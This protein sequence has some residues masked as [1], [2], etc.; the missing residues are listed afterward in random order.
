MFEF[1]AAPDI[2]RSS[3]LSLWS[4][5]G[6]FL[7]R[8]L[9][10]LIVFFIGGI[11]SV[12]LGKLAYY[13]VRALRID[14]ALRQVGFKEAWEK[15]GFKL[16]S[17]V[18]F[19]EIVRWFF[20]IVFLM[21]TMDILGLSEVS[22]FLQTVVLYIPNVFVAAIILLIGILLAKF[23]EETVR[24]SVRAAGLASGNF[25]GTLARWA[26]FVFS[27]LLALSQLN[28]ADDIVRI[29]VIGLVGAI[30]LAIGLSCG[31]GGVKHAEE[32][33]GQLRKKIQD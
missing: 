17:P 24:A 27:L 21:A 26:V 16:N 10:A 1:L 11:V 32:L 31:L 22:F 18:F 29:L 8:L 2:I 25:L 20:L 19:Y 30:S 7:P 23:L 4:Q 14:D 13:V 5:V 33:L 15:S 12:L 3:L 6:G 9:A 28:V